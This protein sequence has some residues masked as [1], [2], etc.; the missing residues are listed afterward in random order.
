MEELEIAAD[1]PL[2]HKRINE[3]ESEASGRLLALAIIRKEG[4]TDLN[5]TPTSMVM[6]GDALVVIKRAARK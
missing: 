1:S 2:A 4:G 3:I 5:P 6:P